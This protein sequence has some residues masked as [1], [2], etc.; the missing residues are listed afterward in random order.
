M[1]VHYHQENLITMTK[2]DIVAAFST[3]ILIVAILA[4]GISLWVAI[5]LL[6]FSLLLIIGVWRHV[7]RKD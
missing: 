5:P 3:I 7:F 6:L 1:I 2:R 4:V